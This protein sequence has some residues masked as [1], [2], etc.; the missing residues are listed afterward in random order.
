MDST[1]LVSVIIPTHNCAAYIGDAVAS[2]L[3]QTYQTFEVIVVDDGST[4]ETSDVLTPYRDRIQYV[5]QDN[6]GPAAA[7]NAGIRQAR[8]NL[9]A[10]LDADDTWSP[11]K[12]E[13]Q[14]LALK[15]YPDA[16]LAFT[17]FHE[18]D[19]SGVHKP[20]HLTG[21]RSSE[22]W[23]AKNRA[24]ETE[25]AYGGMYQEFLR[26]NWIATCSVIVR[27]D[28]LAA[29]G[30]FDEGISYGEDYDLWLRIARRYRMLCNNRV[31]AGVRQ[32]PKSLSGPMGT[33]NV[34]YGHAF[35]NILS[36]HLREKSIPPDL[37]HVARE[38]VSRHCWNIGRG[39][40]DQNRLAEARSLFWQAVRHQPGH[41]LLWLYLCASCLPLL[42]I[43]AIRRIRGW[44]K[45][46]L[47]RPQTVAE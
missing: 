24:A 37:E 38:E 27:R 47:G 9:I 45:A 15:A 35:V 39:R 5:Y 23:F 43:K 21:Q 32:R 36:K 33:R 3:S 40:F 42:I 25:L 11:R 7:R 14:V 28:V 4:D 46:L 34:V 13:L 16:G 22:A 2:V 31:L 30:C 29:V 20:S 44:R 8:G 19:E 17:D 6:Q 26:A 1:P 41:K 18:F 12:L 10:F